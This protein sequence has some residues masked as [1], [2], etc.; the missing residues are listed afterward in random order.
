MFLGLPVWC[1]AI[2]GETRPSGFAIL[3]S[4]RINSTANNVRSRIRRTVARARRPAAGRR[5]LRTD[6]QARQEAISELMMR[7]GLLGCGFWSGWRLRAQRFAGRHRPIPRCLFDLDDRPGFRA[8]GRLPALVS[9][10][11]DQAD[12][13]LCDLPRGR[14]GRAGARFADQDDQERRRRA[15]EQDGLQGRLGDDARQRAEDDAGQVGQ[16]HRHG[17]RRECWRFGAGFCRA[18][19]RRGAAARH[20]PSRISSIRTACMRRT[21]T[22][23][24]ATSPCWS[25]P[26]AANS[27]N[28]RR[29]SRSRGSR[30]A[31]RR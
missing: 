30:P 14:G 27:R 13:R 8:S 5:T 26:S 31:R 15:A 23:P 9:G 1:G 7:Q 17:G 16:R 2:R 20:D 12:D 28:M 24:R 4:H 29:I 19:E 6:G 22:P 3:A 25:A 18:H 11:A 21:S 10:L